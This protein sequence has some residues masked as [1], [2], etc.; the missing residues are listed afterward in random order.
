MQV[1]ISSSA[2]NGMGAT[3]N[4]AS[5]LSVGDCVKAQSSA[6][7]TLVL[8]APMF[9]MWLQWVKEPL[10]QDV[11]RYASSKMTHFVDMREMPRSHCKLR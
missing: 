5:R 7:S 10:L 4:S 2:D 1:L 8:G 9:G 3:Q 11:M 6:V